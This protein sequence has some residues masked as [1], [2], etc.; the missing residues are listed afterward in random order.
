MNI[1]VGPLAVVAPFQGGTPEH[2]QHCGAGSQLVEAD[3]SNTVMT[4]VTTQDKSNICGVALYKY[5]NVNPPLPVKA[6]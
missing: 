6:S 2:K 3:C 1:P 4:S 5:V